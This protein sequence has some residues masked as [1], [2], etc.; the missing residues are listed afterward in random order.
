M[1][2]DLPVELA[3]RYR[4]PS[5]QTRV[6]TEAWALENVY[7][8]SCTSN[9]IIKTPGNTEAVDFVCPKCTALF[10]LKATR[11][12]SGRKV[13]DAA[14]D[15]MM[16][17]ISEDRFPHLFLLRYNLLRARVRDLLVV[18]SFALPVSAIEAR[19]PLRASARRAGWIGCNI[20][21]DLVPP[22]GRISIVRDENPLAAV[23]V[24]KRFQALKNLK[25]LP[26]RRRGWTLDVLTVLRSLEKRTFTLADAYSF[27]QL[28]AR[29]HPEN[30]NVRPK[31]RQQLQVIRDLG[32]L[33]FVGTGMYRWRYD[34][35]S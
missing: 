13:P 5:Q 6:F 28:L 32:Y 19:K 30:R 7:C 35:P 10:Q 11:K 14:Y 31:I 16:R 2:L 15:A 21:L 25:L 9:A 17:A 12:G 4:S 34:V 18:P 27:E 1:N 26:V 24:R 22:E 3:Q 29:R 33:D 8:P 20:V 23:L